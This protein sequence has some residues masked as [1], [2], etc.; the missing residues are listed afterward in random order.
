LDR[1]AVFFPERLKY[2]K[3]VTGIGRN[4]A[5]M[6]KTLGF[7][8]SPKKDNFINR[9]FKLSEYAGKVLFKLWLVFPLSVLITLHLSK[10]NNATLSLTTI[11]VTH[12]G[13]FFLTSQ[14]HEF[15]YFFP[16]AFLFLA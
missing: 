5:A 1:L 14:N 2:I 7:E 10:Q 3:S 6:M 9:H 12:Q 8:T 13:S 11:P 15:H 16:A 4:R